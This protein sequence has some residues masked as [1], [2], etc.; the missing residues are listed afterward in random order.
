[1]QQAVESLFSNADIMVAAGSIIDHQDA[2]FP[3]ERR[4]IQHAVP[5]RVREFTAGRICARIALSRLQQ[6]PPPMPILPGAQRAPIWPTG[7]TGSITHTDDSVAVVVAPTASV[8][9]IGLDME[10]CSR[11]EKKLWPH[12]FTSEETDWLESLPTPE[13]AQSAALFFSAKESFFKFQF[14]LHRQWIDFTEASIRVID[15]QT[16]NLKLS[17]RT[18]DS[19]GTE[20]DFSGRYQFH[21]DC[22]ITGIWAEN[23]M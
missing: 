1:M 23:R 22:V 12:L 15:G 17:K 7:Y 5:K 3:E 2:L 6:P 8:Q 4:L 21:R 19:L 9:S 13:Q 10:D 11:V 18:A 16:F 20:S 14:P